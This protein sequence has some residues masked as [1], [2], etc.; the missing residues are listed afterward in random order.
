M[1]MHTVISGEISTHPVRS[2]GLKFARLGVI[3]AAL[4]G[5]A[6][7]PFVEI[8]IGANGRVTK[9]G[10]EGTDEYGALLR[11][12]VQWEDDNLLCSWTHLSHPG[13]GNGVNDRPDYFTGDH[14]GCGWLYRWQ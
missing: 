14:F 6:A 12:G 3:L 7:T 11:G 10:W 5:C 13:V 9:G 2:Y 1:A 4:S 8:S